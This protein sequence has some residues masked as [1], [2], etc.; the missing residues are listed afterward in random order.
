MKWISQ[1][2]Q[3]ILCSIR[4]QLIVDDLGVQFHEKSKSQRKSQEE[5]EEAAAVKWSSP[6]KSINT[7]SGK[8]TNGRNGKEEV[9]CLVTEKPMHL[10]L[11]N[12]INRRGRE[13]ETI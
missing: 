5:E 12:N 2:I 1:K 9:Q 13:I 10:F 7:R 3:F 11:K 8:R 6:V 4:R